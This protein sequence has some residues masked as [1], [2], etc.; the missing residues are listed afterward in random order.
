MC[1]CMQEQTRDNSS[2]SLSI[3]INDVANILA[4]A[5]LPVSYGPAERMKLTKRKKKKLQA[6]Q[7]ESAYGLNK[8]EKSTMQWNGT[9]LNLRGEVTDRHCLCFRVFVISAESQLSYF[10]LVSQRSSEISFFIHPPFRVY[11]ILYLQLLHQPDRRCAVLRD[12]SRWTALH[13]GNRSD[14]QGVRRVQI[15]GGQRYL[16]TQ[17]VRTQPVFSCHKKC[18]HILRLPRKTL[19]DTPVTF[20]TFLLEQVFNYLIFLWPSE[21][22]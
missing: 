4:S 19:F 16:L 6:K 20:S 3:S 1:V 2:I 8:S 5:R 9:I 12:R 21:T 10:S 22:R 15:K 13:K 14:V 17:N 7:E 11:S 18:R